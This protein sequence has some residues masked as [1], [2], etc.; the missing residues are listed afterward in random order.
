MGSRKS[1]V[2]LNH[3]LEYKERMPFR[4]MLAMSQKTGS[5][6]FCKLPIHNSFSD[7]FLELHFN[8]SFFFVKPLHIFDPTG[9]L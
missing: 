4:M 6:R 9:A 8:I 7:Q 2:F 3:K 1:H 5:L